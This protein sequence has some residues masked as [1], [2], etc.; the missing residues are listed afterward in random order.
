MKYGKVQVD[1][2]RYRKVQD[3]FMRRWKVYELEE[4]V[5]VSRY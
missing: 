3:G 5:E 2:R 4:G 1:D